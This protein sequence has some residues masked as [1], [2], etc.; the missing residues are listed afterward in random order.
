[1]EWMP[2]PSLVPDDRLLDTDHLG[3]ITLGDHGLQREVLTL[4]VRQSH[5]LL[6]RLAASPA[7]TAAI[8]HT[9]KG[10]ARGIGAVSAA[11]CAERLEFAA[12]DRRASA[13]AVAELRCAVSETITAI[14][15]ILR[16]S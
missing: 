3:R 7:E 15:D 14:E 9:L 6:D 1:M 2:S 8:A 11:E 13:A 10:S 5:A 4:F 16:L 12:G